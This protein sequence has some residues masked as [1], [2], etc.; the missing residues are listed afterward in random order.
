MSTL[1]IIENPEAEHAR[2]DRLIRDRLRALS[3]KDSHLNAF[4][5]DRWQTSCKWHHLSVPYKEE[6]AESLSELIRKRE[7]K[8]A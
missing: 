1:P 8:A 6:V 2:L 7:S 4:V 3:R 5:E